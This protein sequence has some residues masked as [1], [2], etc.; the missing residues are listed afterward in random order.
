MYQIQ[1]RY[2]EKP[3]DYLS[4]SHLSQTTTYIVKVSAAIHLKKLQTQK[5]GPNLLLLFAYNQQ[6]MS[7]LTK[8]QRP[9][10]IF[11][12]YLV[13]VLFFSLTQC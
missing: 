9:K 4:L 12:D 5:S 13:N 1:I 8:F 10:I 3:H 6:T 2:G 7:R 11:I